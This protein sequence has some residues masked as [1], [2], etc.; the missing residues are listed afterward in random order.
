MLENIPAHICLYKCAHAVTDNRNKVLK[1][2][3]QKIAGKQ[4]PHNQ[5]KRFKEFFRQERIHG[6]PR[7]IGKDQIHQ[8]NGKRKH[9]VKGKSFPVRPDI[10]GKDGE[11]APVK[12]NFPVHK[13]SS[14]FRFFYYATS[15]QA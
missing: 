6:M 8:S 3:P 4:K 14:S 15:A 11:I 5:E 10:G 12:I 7:N 13:R 2:R 9:H 1:P